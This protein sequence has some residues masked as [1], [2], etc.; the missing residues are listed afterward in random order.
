MR[1]IA[2][3]F[4]SLKDMEPTTTWSPDQQKSIGSERRM[5]IHR[6]FLVSKECLYTFSNK[7]RGR[8]DKSIERI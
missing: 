2:P 7:D 5:H 6:R 4:V 8:L 3:A 1:I